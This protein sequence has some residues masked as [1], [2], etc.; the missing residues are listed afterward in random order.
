ML[1]TTVKHNVEYTH[2]DFA[3]IKRSDDKFIILKIR[4]IKDE[5][6]I[7]STKEINRCCKNQNARKS[8]IK[9][10]FSSIKDNI[11]RVSCL[12][13]KKRFWDSYIQKRIPVMMK[14]CQES[15]LAKKWTFKGNLGKR[16]FCFHA[17]FFI[18]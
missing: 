16:Q 9:E 15:W 14:G 10:S 6:I 11:P 17:K 13:D 18:G 8:S 4:N 3:N 1:N 12:M 5:M 7:H 2:I